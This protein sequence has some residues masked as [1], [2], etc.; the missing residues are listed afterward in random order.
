ALISQ[1]ETLTGRSFDHEGFALYMDRINEQERLYE[2]VSAL[3]ADAERCPI[4]ISEQIPNV[5]IPQWH[6]G[7]AWAIEHAG[8][9]RDEVAERVLAGSGVVENERIRM[10]WIG[11]G[12]WFDTSFYSAFEESHAAVFA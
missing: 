12:L 5:M 6:R 2:E 8:R 7:S 11:A 4:R 1:L 10:M 9:F 3:I